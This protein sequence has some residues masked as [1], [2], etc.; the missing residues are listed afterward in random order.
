MKQSH[1]K[2]RLVIPIITGIVIMESNV[3]TRKSPLDL[4]SLMK[5]SFEKNTV[6]AAM[7]AAAAI[8][9]EIASVCSIPISFKIP[10]TVIGTAISLKKQI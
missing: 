7:G 3:L 10:R 2:T 1:Y 6:V 8:I 5:I 4:L 9:I